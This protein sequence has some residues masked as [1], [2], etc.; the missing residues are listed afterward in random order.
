MY[1]MVNRCERTSEEEILV[2]VCAYRYAIHERSPAYA[3][4]VNAGINTVLLKT[5]TITRAHIAIPNTLIS[6][7]LPKH[8]TWHVSHK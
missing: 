3:V 4:P 5:L 2:H 6:Q 1:N 8:F 7:A